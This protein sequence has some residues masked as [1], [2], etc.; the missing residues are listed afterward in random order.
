MATSLIFERE[1]YLPGNPNRAE[2][3]IQSV[4]INQFYVFDL[5]R[6]G[7]WDEGEMIRYRVVLDDSAKPDTGIVWFVNVGMDSDPHNVEQVF[8][9]ESLNQ[10]ESGLIHF[11][12][13]T[14]GTHRVYV[15]VHLGD[16]H[17]DNLTEE[18]YYIVNNT[19]F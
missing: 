6:V 18:A 13:V 11:G 9:C 14:E 4:K 17:I 7:E 10:A 5:G 15:V 8:I 3:T 19:A 12:E 16:G 2:Q 1:S